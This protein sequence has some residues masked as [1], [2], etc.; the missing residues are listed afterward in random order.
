M[1]F[2]TMLI[3]LTAL[4]VQSAH[5]QTPTLDGYGGQGAVFVPNAGSAAGA[6]TQVSTAGAE[7]AP[8]TS[9]GDEGGAPRPE[10]RPSNSGAPTLG[11]SDA[12]A[13]ERQE[14]GGTAARL[15]F[16]GADIALL[17]LGG[18]VMVGVGM[19]VRRLSPLRT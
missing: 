16:T 13:L 1:K 9:T 3:A 15:P 10:A 2:L 5:A 6:A 18:L 7:S 11:A 4:S 12:A 17:L 8:A 14:P 19:G